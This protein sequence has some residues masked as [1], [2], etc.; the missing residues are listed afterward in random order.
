[1][2][3]TREHRLHGLEP[4]NLLAF[5]ALLGLLR[6]L[7]TATPMWPPPRVAWAVDTFPLRPVLTLPVATERHAIVGAAAAGVRQLAKRHDFRP[8]KNLKLSLEEA[9]AKLRDAVAGSDRYTAELW[10]ALV[11]DAAVRSKK[12]EVEP[13]PLCLMFGQGYQHFL[14]RLRAVP[15]QA[16]P[17]RGPGLPTYSV[18]ETDCL[19]EALFT[20]WARPDA[21]PSFRWDPHEDVRYALRATNPTDKKTKATTQHGA[22]RLAAVGLAA[23]TAAPARRR[24]AGEVHLAVLGGDRMKDGSFTLTWPIWREPISLAAIRNLL[25]H[26]GLDDPATCAE[27]GIVDRRRSRRISVGKYMNFTPAVSWRRHTEA[28]YSRARDPALAP[29]GGPH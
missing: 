20:P 17:D 3:A 2:S 15:R 8:Y 26:P 6:A 19:I 12:A 10:A 29:E 28:G 13:T 23:L 4:D 18:S 25:G 7:E 5:L 16:Q 21:T 22:N 11:S 9:R 14:E 27:L 1:M 24:A